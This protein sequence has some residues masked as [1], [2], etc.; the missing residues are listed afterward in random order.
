MINTRQAEPSLPCVMDGDVL[1]S[2]SKSF[3]NTSP[4]KRT[5]NQFK[6]GEDN[7]KSGSRVAWRDGWLHLREKLMDA[8][9]RSAENKKK[10]LGPAEITWGKYTIKVLATGYKM[11]G[12]FNGPYFAFQL[13]CDGVQI[14]IADTCKPV[15]QHFNVWLI[16][17]GRCCLRYGAYECLLMFRDIIKQ[18]GGYIQREILS[19]VDMRLDLPGEDMVEFIN[20]ARE[21]RYVTR[22]KI[23]TEFEQYKKTLVFGK[24]PMS[25]TIYDKLAQV[26]A[27][28]ESST[29]MDVIH[30]CWNGRMP[31]KAIRIEFRIGRETLVAKGIDSPDDYFR[32]RGSL[33]QYLCTKWIRFTTTPVK[34]GNA[35]RTPTLPLWEN[36]TVGFAQWAGKP[37]SE[38]LSPLPPSGPVDVTRQL[39]QGYG[40][41]RS[42]ANKK[43]RVPVPY[44]HYCDLTLNHA[45]APKKP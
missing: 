32:K 15:S 28:C 22:S 45:M 8:K 9:L 2:P 41:L 38:P 4:Q 3:S 1:N 30:R 34:R 13:E 44:E 24:Y 18:A 42:I 40:L 17:D 19:R 31:N 23:Y 7:I 36:V 37:G 29:T 33:I 25:L 6:G 39:K 5:Q 16:A 21:R 10:K 27:M 14:L 26:N 12:R 11:G 43:E 35:T 20:A